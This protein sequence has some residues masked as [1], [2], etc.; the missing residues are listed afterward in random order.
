MS[1]FYSR[2]PVPMWHIVSYG[3]LAAL[4]IVAVG[5]VSH[6]RGLYIF[7]PITGVFICGFGFV[8]SWSRVRGR[9]IQTEPGKPARFPSWAYWIFF[10]GLAGS[11]ALKLWSLRRP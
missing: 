5:Y 11:V 3:I 9:R 7:A 4:G 6:D 8:L 10:G 1:D 2:E